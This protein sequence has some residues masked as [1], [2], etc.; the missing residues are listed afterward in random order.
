MGAED[1]SIVSFKQTQ[2]QL[3]GMPSQ[4]CLGKADAART[5]LT[6]AND[7]DCVKTTLNDMILL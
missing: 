1:D 7:P 4:C 3:A 6:A 2:V 5:S